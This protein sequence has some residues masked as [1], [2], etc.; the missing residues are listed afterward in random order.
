M[1]VLFFI[2]LFH[3]LIG[4]CFIFS[5]NAAPNF[6]ITP[7]SPCAGQA[8]TIADSSIGNLPMSHH[9]DISNGDWK[10]GTGLS[11]AF[12]YFFWNP[13]TYQITYCLYYGLTPPPDTCITKWITVQPLPCGNTEAIEGQV[14][15]DVNAN[16][17]FDGG[18]DFPLF[19]KV[20]DIGGKP[21]LT[22]RNGRYEILTQSGNYT[23]SLGNP[24]PFNISVPAGGSYTF[25]LPGNGMTFTG[26]FALTANS[27]IQDLEVVLIPTGPF[28][29][30][31][32]TLVKGFVLNNGSNPM[33]GT[34]NIVYGD[35][36]VYVNSSPGGI[37]NTSA[38][39]IDYSFTNLLPFQSLQYDLTFATPSG[40]PLGTPI[41]IF[42]SVL[43]IAGDATPANNTSA[44]HD[45]VIGAFDPNDKT[46]TPGFGPEGY[47]LPDQELTYRIRFQNTGTDTA[48]SVY[49]LDTLDANLDINSI[50]MLGA[51]HAYNMYIGDQREV[52][53]QFDNILLPDSNVN[54]PLSHG[55]VMFKIKPLPNLPDF[56]AIPNFA[57]IYFDF[58][59]PVRTNTSLT[60]INRATSIKTAHFIPMTVSPNP[61]KDQV[62]LAFSLTETDAPV[63]YVI[64]IMGRKVLQ[65]QLGQLGTG[66]HHAQLDLSAQSAGI[67]FIQ[68][69]SDKIKAR[70]KVILT[71]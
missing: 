4:N 54:E 15:Y 71:K 34:L 53:W 37:H 40:V 65:Q 11:P 12:N 60:T 42:A 22:D 64:D 32:N 45:S 68:L 55:F 3:L 38:K 14:Y 17:V 43:P 44:L 20:V 47:V 70:K 9:F 10:S 36:L 21:V 5:Q 51:S 61:A 24:G 2:F 52:R 6:T 41:D 18:I 62:E 49:L 1:R 35:S 48:F 57:D 7:R 33:S 30:T 25:T 46:V 13:G 69:Q 28:R 59:A 66:N 67:Y 23:V 39:T 56:T 16:N 8:I 29:R 63:V 50:Q 19:L 58:N 31:R 26:D 27:T